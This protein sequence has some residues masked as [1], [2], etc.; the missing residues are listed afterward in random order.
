MF[1]QMLTT[2]ENCKEDNEL[3]AIFLS[4]ER[5]CFFGWRRFKEMATEKIIAVYKKN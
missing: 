2:L 5:R 4:G 3:R 1:E